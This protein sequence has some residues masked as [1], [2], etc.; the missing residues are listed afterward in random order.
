MKI[1]EL[2][3][4]IVDDVIIYK[5]KNKEFGMFED[6]YKGKVN[7]IPENMLEMKIR[8]VGASKKAV[9]DIQIED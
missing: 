8:C 1:K 6:L 4:V 2:I 5:V 7:N 9:V 3:T